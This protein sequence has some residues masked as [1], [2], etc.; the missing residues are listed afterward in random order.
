MTVRFNMSRFIGRMNPMWIMAAIINFGMDP[1]LIMGKNYN[2]LIWADLS[3]LYDLTSH[4][5]TCKQLQELFKIKF[6]PVRYS[7]KTGFHPDHFFYI[8]SRAVF[9][10]FDRDKLW[11]Y[12]IDARCLLPAL[13]KKLL[14]NIRCATDYW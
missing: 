13:S 10:E 5:M 6:C 12:W 8:S 2:A 1:N 4:N 3:R 11:F 9:Y 14:S 7:K